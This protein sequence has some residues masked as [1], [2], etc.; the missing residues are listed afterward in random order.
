MFT[1]DR[2]ALDETGAP[3]RPGPGW[4][5]ALRGTPIVLVRRE[6]GRLRIIEEPCGKPS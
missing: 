5:V 2:G 4:I 1:A 3:V 6:D